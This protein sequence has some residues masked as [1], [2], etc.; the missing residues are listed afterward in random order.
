ME[1]AGLS[2]VRG[3]GVPAAVAMITPAASRQTVI[4]LTAQPHISF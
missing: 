2:F 3:R 1:E 4:L